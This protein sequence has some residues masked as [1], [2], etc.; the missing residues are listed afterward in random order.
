VSASSPNNQ[1]FVKQL[2]EEGTKILHVP[3]PTD[4]L[5]ANVGESR[6]I[7]WSSATLASSS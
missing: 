4:P 2:I 1:Q 3:N 5:K 7:S 6:T